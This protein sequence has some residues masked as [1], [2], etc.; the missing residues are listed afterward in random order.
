MVS[1]PLLSRPGAVPADGV[2]VGVAW[3][4]G[5]PLGEQRQLAAGTATVDLSHRG[6]IELSGPDRGKLLDGLA[7]Q[8]L[9]DLVSGDIREA[10][11]LDPN[12]RVEHHFVVHEYDE[13]TRAHNEPGQA[14]VLASFFASMRFMLDVEVRDV[15]AEWA[16]VAEPGYRLIPRRE[17]GALGGPLAG[18]WAR[19]ALRVAAGRPRLGLDTD[20]K[21]IP[22]EVGWIG[23]AV[24][25]SKGCYRGQETVARVHNLGKPPRRLVL[26]H[27][28]GS[29]DSLPKTGDGIEYDGATVGFLGTVAQHYELGPIALG[30]VKRSVP[31]DATLMVAGVP[32]AQEVLV[33][34]DAGNQAA[35]AARDAF[36]V[37][38]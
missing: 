34:P 32:A 9:D 22:H 27:L 37:T 15:T 13:V 4:Y 6:V 16:V 30:L 19:E 2:D 36:R 28:D 21:T 14:A 7:S 3:H 5:D 10:L 31:V 1:S 11:V 17:L 38:R 24:H 33:D 8:K 25:L 29:A 23:E 20:D 26:L 12:G 18:T 35:R